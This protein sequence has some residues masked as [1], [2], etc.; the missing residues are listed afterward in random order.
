MVNSR[1]LRLRGVVVGGV[2]A[3]ALFASACVV[4]VRAV[5]ASRREGLIAKRLAYVGTALSAYQQRH[6][7]LPPAYV[8]DAQGRPAHSWRVLLL[9]DL[10]YQD[11][12]DRYDFNEP[13]DGP[14]NRELLSEVPIEYQSA[15]G[16]PGGTDIFAVLGEQTAWPGRQSVSLKDFHRGLTTLVL[17]VHSHKYTVNWMEPRDLTYRHIIS[18][19][20]KPGGLASEL[21]KSLFCVCGN[22]FLEQLP[23]DISKEELRSVLTINDE[24]LQPFARFRS[25]QI[26]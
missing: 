25:T 16:Q 23:A 15:D 2:I 24:S 8:P 22:G 20:D 4:A 3:A 12:F 19:V 7:S 13:W 10:G 14:N 1:R 18:S 9:P 5:Q 6:G 11:L 21:G 26:H 17:L